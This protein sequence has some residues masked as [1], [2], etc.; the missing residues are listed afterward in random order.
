MKIGQLLI[1]KPQYPMMR[2]SLSSNENLIGL[3]QAVML[4]RSD[5]VGF[6]SEVLIGEKKVWV[7]NSELFEMITS[8]LGDP[9]LEDVDGEQED[10]NEF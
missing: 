8:D 1:Y 5:F 2:V 7:R 3:S 4:L 9:D 10:D 6:K